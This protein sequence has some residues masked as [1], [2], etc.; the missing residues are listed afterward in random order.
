MH[1]ITRTTDMM[2]AL[3]VRHCDLHGENIIVTNIS[4]PAFVFIDFGFADDYHVYSCVDV[5]I[6]AQSFLC[7]Y[8]HAVELWLWCAGPEDDYV[9]GEWMSANWPGLYHNV[10]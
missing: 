7:C 9:D 4:P 2:H 1:Y 3:G 10:S 8:K 5:Q 6:P